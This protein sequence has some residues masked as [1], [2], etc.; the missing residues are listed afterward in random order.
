MKQPDEIELPFT[1]ADRLALHDTNRD[2]KEVLSA[3]TTHTA[4]DKEHFGRQDELIEK[5]DERLN[6]LERFQSKVSG[7]S[8]L[9]GLVVGSAIREA[10]GFFLPH[11]P[12]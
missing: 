11:H 12:Q 3:I 4:E 9:V 6:R 1:L 2:V 10:V 7:I 8:A 5:Q